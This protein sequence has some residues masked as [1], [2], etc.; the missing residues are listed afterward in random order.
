VVTTDGAAGFIVSTDVTNS[1]A[2][3]PFQK[4]AVTDMNEMFGEVP[5]YMLGDGLF[6]D[7]ETVHYLELQGITALVPAESTGAVE[8]DAA[9]RIDPQEA[10]CSDSIDDLPVTK[11]TKRFTRK[12]FIFDVDVD[13]FYC[14]MGNKL[15]FC[16]ITK[17]KRSSGT[18]SETRVY[19]AQ[20][21]DCRVCPLR[22]SCIP[23]HHTYRRV[24]RMNRS[25]VLDRVAFQMSKQ[26][27]K[28][29]Y[30]KR[31]LIAESP[32]AHIKH[33]MGI[34]RF[35]HRGLEKVQTEWTWIC[36]A[37]NLNKLIRLFRNMDLNGANNIQKEYA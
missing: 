18:I 3:H 21:E 36:A 35:L 32:F 20:K 6:T 7:L 16:G 33:A 4:Q 25:E 37:Y 10:V 14:P 15:C 5:Q 31:K 2:E 34:R 30:R 24:E 17:H 22:E 1:T 12:A 26:E 11:R 27:I 23:S 29:R 13:C 8:G 19:K 9:Y 28:K